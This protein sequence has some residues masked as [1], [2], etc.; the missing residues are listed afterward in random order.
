MEGM[1]CWESHGGAL[2]GRNNLM[3]GRCGMNPRHVSQEYGHL[4][5]VVICMNG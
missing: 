4:Y 3:M 2:G 1:V 5:C